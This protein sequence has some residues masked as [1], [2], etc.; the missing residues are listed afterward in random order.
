MRVVSVIVVQGSVAFCNDENTS[1][2]YVVGPDVL[3][4]TAL[5]QDEALHS[6]KQ[7]ESVSDTLG[8]KTIELSAHDVFSFW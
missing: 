6:V 8:N 2:Q 4:T 5:H 7:A 1:W 3:Y